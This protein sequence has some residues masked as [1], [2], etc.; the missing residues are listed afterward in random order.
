MFF[1]RSAALSLSL[2]LSEAWAGN[3]ASASGGVPE[4]LSMKNMAEG[5]DP[6]RVADVWEDLSLALREVRSTED[7]NLA[8]SRIA[9]DFLGLAEMGAAAQGAS[10]SAGELDELFGFDRRCKEAAAQI[11]ASLQRLRE[12]EHFHSRPLVAA[13]SLAALL[14]D[15]LP[16]ARGVECAEELLTNNHEI[17]VKMLQQVHD[18][19]SADAI[20][21]L[22]KVARSHGD[23]LEQFSKRYRGVSPSSLWQQERA[24]RAEKA[25][26]AMVRLMEELQKNGYYGSSLLRSMMGSRFE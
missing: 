25:S 22:V 3:V 13:L 18:V 12:S 21:K 26:A 17:I 19:N 7:A 23:A 2:V 10:A 24:A 9:V 20:A 11:S 15:Q 4:P 5:V 8:A 1:L 14:R 6:R 16:D